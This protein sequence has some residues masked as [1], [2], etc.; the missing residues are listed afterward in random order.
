MNEMNWMA[1]TA[2]AT[3]FEKT[4]D[5]LPLLIPLILVQFGLM[6][7]AL[8]HILKHDKYKRGNRVIWIVVSCVFSIIGPILYIVLGKEED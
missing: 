7:Y 6:A 1:L 2:K 3:F 5:F 8:V 4:E